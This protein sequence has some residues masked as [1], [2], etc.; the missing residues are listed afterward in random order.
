MAGQLTHPI[1]LFFLN[2]ISHSIPTFLELGLQ[3]MR[4]L[5]KKANMD[6][7]TKF[8]RRSEVRDPDTNTKRLVTRK[9]RVTQ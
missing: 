6:V 1:Y 9:L 4:P 5:S 8:T 2:Y 7:D 3:I